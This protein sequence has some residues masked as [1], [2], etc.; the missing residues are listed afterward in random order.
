MRTVVTHIILLLLLT[1]CTAMKQTKHDVIV[2]SK[3]CVTTVCHYTT[4][5]SVSDTNYIQKPVAEQSEPDIQIQ[6]MPIACLAMIGFFII[7][8]FKSKKIVST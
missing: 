1:G 6:W 7:I 4:F 3:E 2:V 5:T 8:I